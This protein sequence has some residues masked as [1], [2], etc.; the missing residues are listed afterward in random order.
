VLSTQNIDDWA[1]ENGLELGEA[2][3]LIIKY[4]VDDP[5]QINFEVRRVLKTASEQEIIDAMETA[6]E[7]LEETSK[8]EVLR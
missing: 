5:R 8:D 1:R 6:V 7:D 2:L 3:Y 4:L